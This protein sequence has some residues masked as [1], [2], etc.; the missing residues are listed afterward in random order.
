MMSKQ[1]KRQQPQKKRHTVMVAQVGLVTLCPSRESEQ[2]FCAYYGPNGETCA[3]T[4]MLAIAG[5][6]PSLPPVV[7]MACPLH[8]D[9][10]HQTVERFLA[11]LAHLDADEQFA[12]VRQSWGRAP[13]PS[14]DF[15]RIRTYDKR[16]STE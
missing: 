5:M 14:F 6:L 12:P 9:E 11:T 4:S 10:I 7:Y 3:S 2:P 8:Y 1:H 15:N 13:F 16:E